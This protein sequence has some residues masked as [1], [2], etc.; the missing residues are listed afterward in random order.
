MSSG[1]LKM[2]FFNPETM[3]DAELKQMRNKIKNMHRLPKIAAG[4]G[5]LGSIVAHRVFFKSAPNH[6][7]L[8]SIIGATAAGYAFGGMAASNVSNSILSRELDYDIIIAN[9]KRQ[10]RKTMNLAGYGQ[11]HVEGSQSSNAGI[12]NFGKVY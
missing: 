7:T 1:D 10:L 9:E 11:E 3:Q 2:L 5:C 6:F 12:K 8:F 4:F